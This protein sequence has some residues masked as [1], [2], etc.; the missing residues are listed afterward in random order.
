MLQVI[1]LI[2]NGTSF[3]IFKQK[4]QLAIQEMKQQFPKIQGADEI[5]FAKGY[6][7]GM[8]KVLE[9]IQCQEMEWK[10]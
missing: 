1:D 6:L 7:F 8:E 10:R 2:F 3:G 4:I 5:A 9:N